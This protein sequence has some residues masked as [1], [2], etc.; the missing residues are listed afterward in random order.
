MERSQDA[1]FN[2]SKIGEVANAREAERAKGRKE[3]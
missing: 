3:N 1:K 2:A